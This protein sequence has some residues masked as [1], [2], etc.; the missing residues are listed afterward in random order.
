MNATVEIKD[1]ITGMNSITSARTQYR[2]Y[3]NRLGEIDC[4]GNKIVDVYYK[5]GKYCYVL[6]LSEE[7]AS[8]VQ[9]QKITGFSIGNR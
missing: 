1:I 6:E 2:E 7:N 8:K 3:K 9:E 4:F 5:D